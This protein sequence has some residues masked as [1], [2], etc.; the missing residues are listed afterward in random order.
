MPIIGI[1]VDTGKL[2]GRLRRWRDPGRAVGEAG[3]A[4]GTGRR[5]RARLALLLGLIAVPV[6]PAAGQTVVGSVVD[7]DTRGR[8]ARA[9]VALISARQPSPSVT[10]SDSLGRFEL[11]LPYGGEHILRV[12]HVDYADREPFHLE[13]AEGETVAVEIRMSSSAV[14]LEPMVVTARTHEVPGGFQE[15]RMRRSGRF[16]TREDVE[17]RGAS[18]T[19]D[20]F[21]GVAGVSLQPVRRGSRDLI[22][23]RGSFG[24]C[25]PAIWLDNHLVEQASSSSL[26]DF[27]SPE[28]VAGIEIYG[29]ATEAPTQYVTGPCGA[30]VIW[31]RRGTRGEEGTSSWKEILGG[32]AA[33]ATLLL[34]FVH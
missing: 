30:I 19:S 23:M 34:L 32:A 27:L 21:R 25:E 2:K 8:I 20:L 6:Q 18:R 29:S 17:A 31:T 3:T 7:R 10:T 1:A 24:R 22:F 13:V 9:E 4:G 33:A 12:T 15:R 28:S 26:D 14:P 5:G 16:I 11:S